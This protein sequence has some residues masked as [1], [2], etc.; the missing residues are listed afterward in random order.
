MKH[1]VG[2]GETV[3]IIAASYQIRPIDLILLNPIIYAENSYVPRG[4]E[5]TL[6]QDAKYCPDSFIG[7]VRT[8]FGHEQLV[9]LLPAWKEKGIRSEIIGYS[10]MKKPIYAFFIGSGKKKIF[11][12]GGW[13]ANEWHTAKLLALF[14]DRLATYKQK[15]EVWFDYDI[16]AILQKVTLVVVPLVNPDGVELVL[17]GIS[18]EHPYY[19]DVLAINKGMTRF[20]HW[21]SNIRGVDLNHQWPAQW[22]REAAES[23]RR[24]WPR[25]YSGQAPLTEPEA[26]AVYEMTLRESFSH[27]IAFHSQGQL[28]YWGYRGYE[29]SESKEMVTRLS[30]ASSYTPVH[31]ADSDGGF[32]D[33]FIQDTGRP[34]FTVEVG[35]GVNPLPPGAFAE[36]WANNVILA[37]EGLQL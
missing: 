10:V 1:I 31:T 23:P 13:H 34:G 16:E 6:P 14:L 19:Q 4:A 12:S 36:I 18:P 30:L 2:P 27:V 5:L 24:P 29:P 25:H 35:S 37:L 8:E 20:D 7:D 21:S 22:E 32:K 28:I 33:W 26:L 17:Q 15:K 11:Y 9:S 3:A